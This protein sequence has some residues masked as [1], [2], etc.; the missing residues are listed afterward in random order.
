MC[1]LANPGTVTCRTLHRLQYALR[2]SS[3]RKGGVR[4]PWTP[5]PKSAPELAA[6]RWRLRAFPPLHRVLSRA[7]AASGIVQM[8]QLEYIQPNKIAFTIWFSVNL[9]VIDALLPFMLCF[10]SVSNKSLRLQKAIFQILHV[11][12]YC[13]LFPLS[14]TVHQIH[15]QLDLSSK[16]KEERAKSSRCVDT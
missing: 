15:W 16:H 9:S 10:A 6:C 4:T 5:P 11:L 2:H 8:V 1:N 7:C 14:G 12:H 3:Y 13:S